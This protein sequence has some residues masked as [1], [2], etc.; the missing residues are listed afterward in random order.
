V[1]RLNASGS[2]VTPARATE[3]SSSSSN[4]STATRCAGVARQGTESATSGA[5]RPARSRCVLIRPLLGALAALTV[6]VAVSG[7]GSGSE[8]IRTPGRAPLAADASRHEAATDRM[9]IRDVIVDR[10][11]RRR[12]GR[13]RRG[14]GW[15]ARGRPPPHRRPLADP[16]GVDPGRGTLM[17]VPSGAAPRARPPRST[18]SARPLWSARLCDPSWI[19]SGR[20]PRPTP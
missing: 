14:R 2:H 5:D 15:P 6:A 9:R 17:T 16:R 4:R 13:L 11:H 18:S 8:S 20:R 3:V 7:C 1:L 10:D 19:C 12:R